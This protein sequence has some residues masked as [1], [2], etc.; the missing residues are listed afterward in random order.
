MDWVRRS[1]VFEKGRARSFRVSTCSLGLYR[2]LRAQLE[3]VG[4]TFVCDGP[5]TRQSEPEGDLENK[6]HI[7][8]RSHDSHSHRREICIPG[9]PIQQW[10]RSIEDHSTLHP[11]YLPSTRRLAIFNDCTPVW[12]CRTFDTLYRRGQLYC[13][14]YISITVNSTTSSP[15]IPAT[16]SC[17]EPCNGLCNG[18][19]PTNL[20]YSQLVTPCG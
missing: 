15:T 8:G 11:P 7:V 13:R 20:S 10:E 9:L 19:L 17:R 4:V 3:R 14:N 5:R 1:S 16:P 18:Y 12:A 6:A 2:A